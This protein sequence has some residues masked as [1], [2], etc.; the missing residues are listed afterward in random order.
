MARYRDGLREATCLFEAAAWHKAIKVTCGRCRR[1]TAFNP[2][3]LWWLF[4][5][6]GW[7]D[8]LSDIARH[9]FCKECRATYG[10]RVRPPRI[11]LVAETDDD[12]QLPLPDERVW[13]RAINRFR[14]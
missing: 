6:K 3:G 7:S 9:L 13:K 12:L 8:N 14:S 1:S 2:H 11:E 10:Q 5:R 4:E